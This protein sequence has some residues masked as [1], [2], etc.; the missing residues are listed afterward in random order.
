MGALHLPGLWGLREQ[1]SLV[2][3][4]R[5]PDTLTPGCIVQG[6]VGRMHSEQW[7]AESGDVAGCYHILLIQASWEALTF[8]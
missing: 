3:G 6:S 4:S 5:N 7:G 8:I 1:L 2:E